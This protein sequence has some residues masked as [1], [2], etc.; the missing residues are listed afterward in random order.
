[1]IFS[2]LFD[3]LLHQSGEGGK[4]IDRRID[5][6]VVKLPVNENLSLSDVTSQ[7]RNGVSDVIVLNMIRLTGM[8]K[9]GIWVIDPFLPRTR[10]AL[11]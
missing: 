6:L 2:V 10:P 8:D 7:V 3:G 4:H 9:M 5:L 11:S 1:M